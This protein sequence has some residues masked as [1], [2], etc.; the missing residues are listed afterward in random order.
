ML[1]RCSYEGCTNRSIKNRFV[2]SWCKGEMLT[3]QPRGIHQYCYYEG[4]LQKAWCNGDTETVL[5]NV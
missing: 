2:H 1:T 4:S 3:L 5:K